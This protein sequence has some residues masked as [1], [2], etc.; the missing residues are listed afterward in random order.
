MVAQNDAELMIFLYLHKTQDYDH[1]SV[2]KNC[3][4]LIG[5]EKVISHLYCA[6]IHSTSAPFFF[7]CDMTALFFFVCFFLNCLSQ[8]WTVRILILVWNDN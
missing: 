2:P 1:L 6:M 3:N 4:K 7:Q 8:K 5:K